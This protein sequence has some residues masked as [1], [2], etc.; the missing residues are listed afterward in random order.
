M[1]I[2]MNNNI[3]EEFVNTILE[4]YNSV[5]SNYENSVA[6]IK[7]TEDNLSDLNHEIEFANNKDMYHGYLLYKEIKEIRTERRKA[8]E[9]VE[10]L[11]DM[12][13]FM[14]SQQ[15]QSFRNK[16]N[17]LKGSSRKVREKQKSRTYKP[18]Q[19][20]DMTIED[21]HSETHGSF[22]DMLEAWKQVGV[23]MKGGKLRK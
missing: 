19:R 21:K 16:L 14:N 1:V 17:Q 22:D 7:R 4:I 23:T 10:L 2:N 18:R 20:T 9:R 5:G 6:T 11:Q 13:D 12:Y 8:K 15:G 3:V